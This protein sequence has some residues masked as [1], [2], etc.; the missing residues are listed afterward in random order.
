MRRTLLVLSATAVLVA[1]CGGSAAT[2]NPQVN[3]SPTDAPQA[4]SAAVSAPHV[5]AAPPADAPKQ[6]DACKLI[7]KEEAAAILGEPVD[8]GAPPTPGSSSCLF[9]A[10]PTTGFSLDGVTI[11]L[12]HLAEFDP[13][14]K[15]IAGITI[16]PVTG[17]GDAAYYVSLGAGYVNLNVRKGQTVFSVDIL[18]SKAADAKLMDAEKSIAM[19]IVGRI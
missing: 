4:A 17:V 7:T 11:G 9:A 3:G 5:T 2:G 12:P 14:K 16:T 10:H 13:N 8:A 15:S 19:L 6:L 1:A 18:L